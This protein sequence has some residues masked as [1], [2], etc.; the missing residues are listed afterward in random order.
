[1]SK[2]DVPPLKGQDCV[3]CR[4]ENGYPWEHGE[5]LISKAHFPKNSVGFVTAVSGGE[6]RVDEC[7][8]FV[9]G[10]AMEFFVPISSLEPL[11]PTKTGKGFDRKIC[12]LCHVLLPSAEFQPN[13]KDSKGVVTTRPS[14][15]SCRRKMVDRQEIPAVPKQ[16]AL[17]KKPQLGTLFSCP[18]CR[19]RSIVGVTAMVVIDHDHANGKI[20]G[21][22]CE[23]CNTGLGRFKNGKDYLRNAIAY[24]EEFNSDL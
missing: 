4:G 24:L 1:M 16:E 17:R 14:C 23:S 12:N 6:C 7:R 3:L 2:A 13:Q 8:V 10:Q 11:D 21:Y 18:I 19:K 15:R 22:L 9:I 20:R 5:R